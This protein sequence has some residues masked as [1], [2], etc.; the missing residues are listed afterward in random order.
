MGSQLPLNQ[1][2]N[3]EINQLEEENLV[4]LNELRNQFGPNIDVRSDDFKN[5]MTRAFN[6]YQSNPYNNLRTWRSINNSQDEIN[7]VQVLEIINLDVS[8]GGWVNWYYFRPD[9]NNYVIACLPNHNNSNIS[10]HSVLDNPLILNNND[11]DN[12]DIVSNIPQT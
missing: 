11:L 1:L 12:N 5:I 2:D 8:D 9:S 6:I 7:Q 10:I 3:I 4:R